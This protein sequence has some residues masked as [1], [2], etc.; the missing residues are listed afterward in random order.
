MIPQLGKL[1]SIKEAAAVLEVGRDSVVR[2]IDRGELKC[3]EFP[4]MGGHG[5]NR[6]RLIPEAELDRF[7]KANFNGFFRSIT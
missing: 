2:L 7:F 6:K 1:Y 5:K 4:L 3:I